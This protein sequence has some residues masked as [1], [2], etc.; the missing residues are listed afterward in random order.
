M[1]RSMIRQS[2]VVAVL[3]VV[4]VAA[5]AGGVARAAEGEGG[6]GARG[7]TP[8]D[9]LRLRVEHN[10]LAL[11]TPL[12]P[13]PAEEPRPIS[14]PVMKARGE[15]HVTAADPGKPRARRARAGA[16]TGNSGGAAV[17][18]YFHLQLTSDDIPGQNVSWQVAWTGGALDV[19][20]TAYFTGQYRYTRIVRLLATPGEEDGGGSS[21]GGG[22]RRAYPVQLFVTESGGGARRERANVHVRGDDFFRLLRTHPAEAEEFIR[23]LMRELGQEAVFAPEPPVAWQVLASHWSPPERLKRD[24]SAVLPGLDAERPSD[25]DAASARLGELGREGALLLMQMPR[26]SLTAEQ[27]S[28][29]DAAIAAHAPLPQAEASRLGEDVPFLLDCLNCDDRAI[30]AAALDRL[31]AVSRRRIEF[32]VAVD[33]APARHAAVAKLR[34]SLGR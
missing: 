27:N 1:P 24:V 13:T 17:P 33:D 3:G 26:G 22:A 4:V 20:R 19:Q 15:V 16:G 23:P 32:D 12:P 6:T 2:I 14:I 28:R 30:R 25:R 8:H 31:S 9:V 29:I 5:G 10:N 7:L 18:H 34:E 21:G 11:Y